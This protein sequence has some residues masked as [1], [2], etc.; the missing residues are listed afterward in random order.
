MASWA[1]VVE[2]CQQAATPETASGYSHKAV[3]LGLGVARGG[4]H[5]LHGYTHHPEV[6]ARVG[7]GL[8]VGH[9]WRS[10]LG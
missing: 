4:D 2:G 10:R 3:G 1:A 9:T 7:Q 8:F 6:S 5:C